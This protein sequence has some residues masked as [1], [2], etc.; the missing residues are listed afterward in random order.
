VKTKGFVVILLATTGL[1][2]L[3]VGGPTSNVE[4]SFTESGIGRFEDSIQ[5][6]TFALISDVH[7]RELPRKEITD[8]E[9][10]KAILH[11]FIT[12]MNNDVRPEFIVQLGD[13]ND[14]WTANNKGLASDDLIIERLKRA[15]N[16]TEGVTDITWFDVV[17]NHE[18]ASGYNTDS[19]TINDKDFSA[20]YTAIN[21]D[22][23]KLEDTWYYR[24]IKG[25]RFIFLNT[26]LPYEGRPHMIPLAEVNWLRGLLE[27][28][29]KPTF[30]FMHV[31][32]SGG[33]GLDY[34]LAINQ[35]KIT[36]LLA[37]DDSFVAGFFGHSH[38]S[39]EWDGLRKQLD[40]AG[41]IYFH[42]PAPHE[43][44][45]NRSGHPWVIV[46]IEPGEDGFTVE[47]GTGVKRSELSE[48]AY[49]LK[50]RLAKLIPSWILD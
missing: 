27:S 22:W 13:L 33:S 29:S 50:E 8:E 15:E 38:H 26:A 32:V 25:Y 36:H 35:E 44:L 18:Y 49:F 34:D 7:L 40:E 45:G 30:V 31:P 19:S 11:E 20:I 12:S 5:P 14:G 3:Y 46:N 6:I 23:S 41:N 24:D 48:F 21:K 43:W 1:A 17:G 47:V 9:G 28:S 39:D 2:W 4:F 16:Y 37:N 10:T 42:I